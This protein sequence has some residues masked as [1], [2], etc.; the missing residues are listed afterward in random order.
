M[1][2]SYGEGYPEEC[3][4]LVERLSG[5]G[6]Y[7]SCGSYE[8]NIMVKGIPRGVPVRRLSLTHKRLHCTV[9]PLSRLQT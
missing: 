4:S 5:L 2:W 8:Y 6:L 3:M 9:F 7:W 1:Y